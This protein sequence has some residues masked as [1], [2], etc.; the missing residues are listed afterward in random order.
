M[1]FEE[2]VDTLCFRSLDRT[3]LS[4]PVK[5]EQNLSVGPVVLDINGA[6]QGRVRAEVIC[7]TLLL[8]GGENQTIDDKN[9]KI[10]WTNF[11]TVNKSFRYTHLFSAISSYG[12]ILHA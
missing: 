12:Q 6:H 3:C 8:P 10:H 5:T 4:G 2:K 1:R 7:D 9:A 11:V